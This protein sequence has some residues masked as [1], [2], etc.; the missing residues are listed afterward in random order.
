MRLN[1]L[2]KQVLLI[3]MCLFALTGQAMADALLDAANAYSAGDYTKAA[4][5]FRPLAKQGI[6]AAQYLLGGMYQDGEGVAQDYKEAVKWSRLA[7]EQGNASSQ[8]NLGA[9]YDQGHG[10]PQDFVLSYM[11]INIVASEATDSD[12]QKEYAEMRDFTA[13][14]LSANQIA[15]AQELARKCTANKFKGC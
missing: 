15:D 4:K 8:Y 13:Q 10:V 5:L 9:M 3:C 14:S 2:L 1:Q 7:A 12:T 6:A 11:W